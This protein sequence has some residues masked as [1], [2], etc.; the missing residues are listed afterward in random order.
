MIKSNFANLLC[1]IRFS[2]FIL[3]F[4]IYHPN[5]YTQDSCLSSYDKILKLERNS[6]D[7][8]VDTSLSIGRR[9]RTSK[10]LV[11][12]ALVL[13]YKTIDA[14]D[15]KEYTK[16]AYQIIHLESRLGNYSKARKMAHN[17]LDKL[18]PNWQDIN[19]NPK[20]YYEHLAELALQTH[21][22]QSYRFYNDFRRRRGF[23]YA[24]DFTINYNAQEFSRVYKNVKTLYEEYGPIY[25]IRYLQGIPVHLDVE[26]TDVRIIA[27]K[28][29]NILIE[30]LL[31]YYTITD[32]IEDFLQ[33]SI[34]EQPFHENLFYFIALTG[35][36]YTKVKGVP[37]YFKFADKNK[38]DYSPS[39]DELKEIKMN[40]QFFQLLKNS[41]KN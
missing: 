4:F 39:K 22:D 31:H 14:Y 13:S 11:K 40:S 37:I 24:C 1:L 16:I 35:N 8:L 29:N 30:S 36:H 28:V 32:L 10:R 41:N 2:I 19:L 25:S 9:I 5:I 20:I 18:Y 27:D 7:I 23:S 3:F 15:C 21:R 17:R 33:S 26:K 38:E 6:N 12:E 34:Q